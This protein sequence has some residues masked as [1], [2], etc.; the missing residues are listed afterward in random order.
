MAEV[1][2]VDT[3]EENVLIQA[4]GCSVTIYPGLGGKIASIRVKDHELMQAP[5]AAYAPRT[6][7]RLYPFRD[8]GPLPM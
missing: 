3:R 5:L 1:S 4:G 2:G 7:T 8:S 6:Q